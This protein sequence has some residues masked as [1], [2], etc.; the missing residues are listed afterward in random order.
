MA[1]S[2][3]VIGIG[4]FHP[5]SSRKLGGYSNQ[6]LTNLDEVARD[7]VNDPLHGLLQSIR[8]IKAIFAEIKGYAET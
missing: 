2:K 7:F 3:P 1:S 8:P 6:P 4:S 5:V